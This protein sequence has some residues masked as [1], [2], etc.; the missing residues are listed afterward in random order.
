VRPGNRAIPGSDWFTRTGSGAGGVVRLVQSPAP[1][2]L[3]L[4]TALAEAGVHVLI[5][6]PLSTGLEGI[7]RLKEAVQTRG[8]VAG[9]A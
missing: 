5:E 6:K 1:N 3:E 2:H 8:L 7:E 4:A 9:V